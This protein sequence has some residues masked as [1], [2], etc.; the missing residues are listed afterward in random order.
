MYLA[1]SSDLSI[2]PNSANPTNPA[3]PTYPTLQAGIERIS[4]ENSYVVKFLE[5]GV[6]LTL[7]I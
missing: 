7:L 2:P 1:N 6:V 3:N 4:A 5:Y